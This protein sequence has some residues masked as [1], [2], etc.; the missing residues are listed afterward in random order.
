MAPYNNYLKTPRSHEA[1]EEYYLPSAAE[2]A[3]KSRFFK[4]YPVAMARL[5]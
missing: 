3:F 2:H 4:I 1:R 5:K